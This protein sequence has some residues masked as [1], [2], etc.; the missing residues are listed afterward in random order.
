MCA[1]VTAQCTRLSKFCRIFTAPQCLCVVCMFSN[2]FEGNDDSNN[3][4]KKKI[5]AICWMRDFIYIY[6]ALNS[7]DC[8]IHCGHRYAR[9]HTDKPLSTLDERNMYVIHQPA[10]ASR[11]IVT[12][13]WICEGMK[14]LPSVG[15]Q[16]RWKYIYSTVV[17]LILSIDSSC[18]TPHIDS[19]AKK[20]PNASSKAIWCARQNGIGRRNTNTSIPASL[21]CWWLPLAVDSRRRRWLLPFLIIFY[22]P[23]PCSFVSSKSRW[24]RGAGG[25]ARIHQAVWGSGHMC[26]SPHSAIYKIAQ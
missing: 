6:L 25:S 3:N 19:Q 1:T 22:G 24:C 18:S 9:S 10:I 16:N 7:T 15:N 12:A 23:W 20:A 21:N 13:A 8:A 11:A 17:F 26:F 4:K 5:I 2:D 14:R